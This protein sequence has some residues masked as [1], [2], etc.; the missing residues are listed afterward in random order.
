MEGYPDKEDCDDKDCEPNEEQR[1]IFPDSGME[2]SPDDGDCD[3]KD[4]DDKAS[5]AFEVDESHLL[6][7]YL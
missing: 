7:Y 3:D 1:P 5:D 6:C 2:E 4:F